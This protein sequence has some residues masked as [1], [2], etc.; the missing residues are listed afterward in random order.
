MKK[1]DVWCSVNVPLVVT[2]EEPDEDSATLKV[3]H[4]FQRGE[5]QGLILRIVIGGLGTID[6]DEVVETEEK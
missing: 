3:E 1:Y 2:V 4:M 5:L 6:I